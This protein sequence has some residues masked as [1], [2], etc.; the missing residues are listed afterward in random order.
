MPLAI[1]SWLRLRIPRDLSKEGIDDRESI[2]AY[3][4]V[5]RWPLFGLIRYLV[6]KQLK[7]H[8]PQGTLLDAG[9]GP[10]YLALAIAQKFPQLK[11]TGID[12][13]KEMLD[14]AKINLASSKCNLRVKFQQANVQQLPFE[15]DSVDLAVSTLSLH[16]W[17]NPAQA[18]Q[19]IYRVLKPGGQ[20]LIFD[21]RR[22]TPRILY[23]SIRCGQRFLA[24]APIRR[25][26]G[27]VGSVWSSFTP[28]EMEKLLTSSPFRNGKIRKGWGWAYIL[29]QK[30]S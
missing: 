17:S 26:N 18:L 5:S 6:I 1:L 28:S 13:S 4:Q 22:D 29:G 3:D 7:R 24:P 19:E 2:L 15:N 12:I 10:G 23:Y 21:L 30:S 11:V 16:H 9:C 25:I 20:L 8:R 14:L 27:G